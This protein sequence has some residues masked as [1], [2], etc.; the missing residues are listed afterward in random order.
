MSGMTFGQY[1]AQLREEKNMSQRKLAE[2]AG[3]IN[4]T[5]SRIEAGSVRPDPATIEKIAQ[6][7]QVDKTLLFIR[8]GYNNEIPEDFVVIARKTGDLSEEKRQ[9]VFKLFNE[10]ID[11]FLLSEDD[12]EE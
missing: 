5:V 10:T 9:E 7:L 2:T 1:L 6:A 8:C 4:S 12:D 11:K 3:L